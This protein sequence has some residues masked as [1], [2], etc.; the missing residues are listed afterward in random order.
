MLFRCFISA[1][2]VSGVVPALAQVGDDPSLEPEGASVA[3]GGERE[4][5]EMESDADQSIYVIQKRAYSKAGDFEITGPFLFTKVNPKF[6]GYWGFAISAAYHIKENFAVELTTAIPVPGFFNRFY[7]DMT[8]D[9]FRFESLTPEEVDLK[10]MSY[11]GALSLQFS[12]LYGK[13]EFYGILVDY[14]FYAT[15][16]I[17]VVS[18]LETCRVGPN[19]D[20]DRDTTADDATGLG[21]RT[22]VDS[23]D[24]FKVTG[25][26]GGGMRV[27]FLDWLGL[28]LELR[29]IVY[30]D[31]DVQPGQTTTDIRNELLIMIGLSFMISGPGSAEER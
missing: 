11:F 22:P 27:F 5:E 25:N 14:D 12:A 10:Q 24:Q 3:T 21:L 9:I 13:L 6:V 30:S 17:G 20:C 1:I 7:S 26:L 23:G 8:S 31:R 18:T 29:D 28:R 2:V 16:G 15:A 19:G 4:S